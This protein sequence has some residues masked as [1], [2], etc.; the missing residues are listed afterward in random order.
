MSLTSTV[1]R[2][3]SA[4]ALATVSVSTVALAGAPVAG[5]TDGDRNLITD[6]RTIADIPV[7]SPVAAQAVLLRD[8]RVPVVV[9]GARLDED[10]SR[11]RVLDDRLDAAAELARTHLLNPVIVSGGST[12]TDCPSE[13][14][15]MERGLRDRGVVNQ[16]LVED[17]SDS[18]VA[19][20][21][22][23]KSMISDRGGLAVVVTSSPHNVRA[24]QNFRDA[25][26]E[27]VAY[28]GGRD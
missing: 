5:A 18:T 16:V 14:A 6:N 24:L 22:N 1:A 13:A 15:A 9:L 19:N 28:V 23:T 27:A 3:V 20:V 11:P 10:C 25:G 12:R 17:R 4:V 8:A 7:V 26:V 2:A 21:E